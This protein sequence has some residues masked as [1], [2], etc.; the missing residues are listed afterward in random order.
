MKKVKGIVLFSGGLDSVLAAKILIDLGCEMVGFHCVLPFFDRNEYLKSSA[1]IDHAAKIQLPLEYYFC[2]SEYINIVKNPPHG[3]G[4]NVNPCIDCKIHFLTKAGEFMRDI[5]ADFVATGEVVGQRPMSQN[6]HTLYHIEKMT[7]L[8]GR[9]LRPL[10]AKILRP[11]IPEQE[12]LIDREKLFAING[13]SRKIQM[14]L[15]AFL[16]ITSHGSPAGGCLFTDP[17]YA[18]RVFDLFKHNSSYLASDLILLKIGRHFRINHSAKII[19]ARNENEVKLLEKYMEFSDIFAVPEFKGPVVFGQGIFTVD[20]RQTIAEILYMYG[21]SVR[22]NDT[23]LFYAGGLVNDRITMSMIRPIE[24]NRLN[25]M[26]IG[27]SY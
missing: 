12:G 14:E 6:R 9:L 19:V 23:I 11:T 22:S 20:E 13:R 24:A 7:G 26:R 3:W 8:S 5:G 16:G 4:K 17:I 21:K 27:A 10:S 18:K 25:S 1:V 15:A 2:T